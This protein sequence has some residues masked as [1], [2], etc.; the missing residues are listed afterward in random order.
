MKGQDRTGQEILEQEGRGKEKARH[1]KSAFLRSRHGTHAHTPRTHGAK[2]HEKIKETPKRQTNHKTP[3][4]AKQSKYKKTHLT[5]NTTR[6]T[7]QK[8]DLTP[9][10]I[11]Y[12][13]RGGEK[14]RY[15]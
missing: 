12:N 2:K 8:N 6:T 5:T 4:N 11:W 10:T 1:Q 13:D 9:Q 3:Q 7:R 15:L 14:G